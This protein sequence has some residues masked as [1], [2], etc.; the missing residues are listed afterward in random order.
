MSHSALS[1]SSRIPRAYVDPVDNA[2]DALAV[3]ELAIHRPLRSEVIAF[4]LDHE[5]R[6]GTIISV[7]DVDD[8]DAIC[9]VA[10]VMCRA[11]AADRTT[12]DLGDDP[13]QFGLVVATVR[14][15]GG[16]VTGDTYRW[17]EASAIATDHGV[18]LIEWF[19]IGPDGPACPRA[20]LGEPERW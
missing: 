2:A 14:P 1:H 8:D 10:E 6:G 16:V 19:V 5:N 4:L 15:A 3:I 11:A 12:I 17:L 7:A 20:L 9:R 13:I 18:E